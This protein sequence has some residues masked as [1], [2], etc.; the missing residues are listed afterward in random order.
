MAETQDASGTF[1]HPPSPEDAAGVV[2]T[3][4]VL[5]VN[6]HARKGQAQLE[7]ARAALEASGLRLADVRALEEPDALPGELSRAVDAG[8]RLVIVG[9]GD[10]TLNCAAHALAGRDVLMGVLPLGTANDFARGLGLSR[11]LEAAAH[12]IAHGA[13][14]AVDLGR[15]DGHVFL[16]AASVGLTSIVAARL[17]P[18]L[19]RRVGQLA[20]PVT[21][22][23]EAWKL[24]PFKAT[25]RTRARTLEVEALQVVVG[26]GR[27]QGGGRIIHPS[28]T[29]D[30]ER[31]SVYVITAEG[32]AAEETAAAKLQRLWR[33][34]RVGVVL[35]RGR[36]LALPQVTHFRTAAL[37]LE[38]DPPLEVNV[39]GELIGK[40]PT[41]F[42]VL[43]GALKVLVPANPSGQ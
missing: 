15:M 21:A 8:A 22:A 10:G 43:P 3:P 9:G 26:N 14:K 38:T 41:T 19:K 4:A 24:E 30:D 27:Y 16:N 29:L 32:S 13:P 23:S 34:A 35:R 1:T 39:D 11:S 28:A 25:L 17:D 18:A 6:T 2:R 5:V 36:H 31:L 37:T 12:V 33:L 40:T 42:S 20:Y 7:A